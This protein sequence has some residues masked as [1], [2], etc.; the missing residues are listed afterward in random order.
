MKESDSDP[1]EALLARAR[2][3]SETDPPC[4]VQ[5]ALFRHGE[6]LAFETFGRA[7]FGGEAPGERDADATTLF[8][9]YS[10]TKAITAGATLLVLQDGL[11]RLSDPVVD[12]LPEFGSNGKDAVTVE[13]LLTH[14]AGF[15]GERFAHVDWEDPALRR[16]HFASWKLEWPPG[17]RFV[18]H[19]ASSMWVLAELISRVTGS[20]YREFMRARIFEPLGL[21]DLFVG[22]PDAEEHRVADVITVGQPMSEAKRAR[23]PVDAPVIGPEI[24]AQGNSPESRRAGSPGG[25][26]IATARDIARYY[27]GLLAD[28]AGRGS[29][30]WRPETLQDAWQIRNPDLVDPMTGQPALRG[31]GFVIAGQEGRMWRGFADGCSPRAFGHMGAGG[32]ISWADPE[33][34]LSFAFLTSGAQQDAA[35]QGVNG[36]KLST[37]A[38]AC[39]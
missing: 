32:Q 7:H 26:G 39:T 6:S 33:T 31:L 30:I 2:R 9:I 37:L 23:S 11:L 35:R 1:I 20:D 10:V 5:V 17:S 25:G 38:A 15:P 36:F 3:S 28:A 29:G 16:A 12:Y 21:H 27:Q 4:A 8:C 22:L 13:Q 14:T 19:G 24:A 18:Y 34:G